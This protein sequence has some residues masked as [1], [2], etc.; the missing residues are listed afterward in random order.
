MVTTSSPAMKSWLQI[1][2]LALL[3]SKVMGI[4]GSGGGT[5]GV[6]FVDVGSLENAEDVARVM[7][8]AKERRSRSKKPPCAG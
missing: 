5:L 2:H 7:D 8:A 3:P 6:A 1:V 4:G